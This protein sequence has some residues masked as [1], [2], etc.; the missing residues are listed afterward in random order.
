MK[1]KY[2]FDL[3][4]K[5]FFLKIK[6][7]KNVKKLKIKMNYLLVLYIFIYNIIYEN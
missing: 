2:E 5:I 6:L 7:I 1:K 3:I 4:K